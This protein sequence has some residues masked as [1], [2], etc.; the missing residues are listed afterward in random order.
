MKVAFVSQPIDSI[1]LPPVRGGSITIWIYHVARELAK[2]CDVIVYGKKDGYLKKI[3]FDEGVEYRLLP[4]AYDHLRG[5]KR[6]ISGLTG[7]RGGTSSSSGANS[8]FSPIKT[9]SGRSDTN[10]RP[11]VSSALYY[12]DYALQVAH[13][14]RSQKCDVVHL[15]NFT[16]LVPVIRLL[17]PGMKIVLHMHCEWLTQLDRKMIERRLG[18]VDAV[19]GC[20][21][22]ITGKIRNTFPQHAERCR[23]VYNGVDTE[24]FRNSNGKRQARD[25]RR[26]RLLFVGRVSPEKGVHVLLEAFQH[27]IEKYPDTELEIV[28]PQGIPPFGSIVG[29]SD[30]R[31]IKELARFYSMSYRSYLQD[32]LCSGLSSQV[33]FT[34]SVPHLDLPE[35]YRQADILI[36]PSLYEAF[37]MTLVESMACQLPVIATRVGGMVEIVE[38]G[39]SG[40]LVEPDNAS[41]LA[42]A[43]L[44]LLS[45]EGLRKTMGIAGRKRAVESFSYEMTA[46][47]LRQCYTRLC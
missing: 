33:F 35:Y 41:D 23:T 18:K 36:N 12:P 37:G 29:L 43:I 28:G 15:H 42:R 45:N 40:L 10:K 32:S 13:D 4:S 21:E 11:L 7:G 19:I 31:R 17:N 16:Q 1:D 47:S 25:I 22:Y 30:E 46:E 44:N 2:D 38:D 26:K 39:K 6:S 8:S 27:V 34:G 9:A 3:V 5:I 14:L 24:H 20:S